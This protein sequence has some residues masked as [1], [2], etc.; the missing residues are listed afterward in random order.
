MRVWWAD[1]FVLS[2]LAQTG[3]FI[4][5][6]LHNVWFEPVVDRGRRTWGPREKRGKESR[7]RWVGQGRRGQMTALPFLPS[8]PFFDL[9]SCDIFLTF[10]W[11]FSWLYLISSSKNILEPSF[12]LW[13][14]IFHQA[15]GVCILSFLGHKTLVLQVWEK[16]LNKELEMREISETK[17]TL[18]TQ[19][20]ASA[21]NWGPWAT[22]EETWALS[23]K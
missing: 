4:P 22:S 1:L 20:W 8:I 15:L 16:V 14:F 18:D 19:V 7:L 12:V 11:Y 5:Q 6:W 17:Q 2:F 13:S 3:M 10:L 23:W 9:S 21:E